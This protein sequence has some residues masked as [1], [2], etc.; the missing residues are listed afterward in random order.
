MKREL[1]F[2]FATA[3]LLAV[4]APAS[5]ASVTSMTNT[6]TATPAHSRGHCP[7]V[8]TFHGTI[9]VA[10]TMGPNDPVQIGYQFERSDPSTG[11]IKYFMV[12]HPGTY[13]VSTTWTLGGPALPHYAGWEKLK[14]WPTRH[15]GGF[16]YAYSPEAH[17][18]VD[19]AG[20]THP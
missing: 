19:C 2:V 20:P 7:A 12:T 9:T 3:A 1:S 15:D 4:A 6:L 16:G 13:P 8:I 18:T 11:P 5:A 10:G 14:A 17:F